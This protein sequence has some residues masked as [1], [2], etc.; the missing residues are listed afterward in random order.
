MAYLVLY[1]PLAGNGMGKKNLDLVSSFAEKNECEFRDV[2]TE[3]DLNRLLEE[4]QDRDI[5]LVG[6]DGTLNNFINSVDTAKVER[7]I[8]FLSSGSGNDFLNDIAHSLDDGPVKINRYLKDLPTVI[9][10]GEEHR[11]INGIGFGLD[12]YCCEEG[13]RVRK[14]TNKPV[15]YTPIALKGFL[16]AYKPRNAVI[17]VDGKEHAFKKVWIAPTMKGRFFG[18]GMKVAPDQDRLSSDR[19]VTTV[20]V[21]GIS[22]L[23]CLMQFPKIFRGEHKTLKGVDIFRG[24]NI[25]VRFDR[26]TPLQVDGETYTGITEY[27]VRVD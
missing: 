12:G 20:I 8:Y 10:N 1:N 22:K 19:T 13:D 18:G 24:K 14:R 26:Q 11:F 15:N 16:Y 23:F 17:T 5:I 9:I 25:T 7:D 4:F 2:T 6:G 27:S 21:S 3:Q